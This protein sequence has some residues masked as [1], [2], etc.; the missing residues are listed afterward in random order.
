M[1]FPPRPSTNFAGNRPRFSPEP[2][3]SPKGNQLI[4]TTP[5]KAWAQEEA[6]AGKKARTRITTGGFLAVVGVLGPP[7]G[8]GGRRIMAW[9]ERSLDLWGPTRRKNHDPVRRMRSALATQPSSQ[10]GG[11]ATTGES[12]DCGAVLVWSLWGDLPGALAAA[13]LP[14][15]HARPQPAGRIVGLC[16]DATGEPQQARAMSGSVSVKR[17][18]FMHGSIGSS[19]VAKVRIS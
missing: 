6:D 15:R 13:G 16:A 3:L 8:P 9:N 12:F 11:L 17:A 14:G 1:G 4:T 7:T 5:A 10:K 18:N 2:D 19:L